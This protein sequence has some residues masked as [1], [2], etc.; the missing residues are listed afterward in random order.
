MTTGI[1]QMI[2]KIF[3]KQQVKHFLLSRVITALSFSKS[4]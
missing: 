3:P 4:S 2:K 1:Q